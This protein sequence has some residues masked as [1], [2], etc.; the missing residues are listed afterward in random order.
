MKVIPLAAPDEPLLDPD[1]VWDGVTGDLALTPIDEPVNPGG[2]RARQALATAIL[3]C[4]MTDVRAEPSELRDGDV[5]RGWPGDSFER[6]A[7][8]PALGSK[9][10][11]L[12]RRV[13]NAETALLAEDYAR[14]ALQSLIGQGAVARFD[15]VATA[16]PERSR[17]DL[18]I[19]G[20]GRT[21]A[22][23]HD[24]KFAVLWE[25]LNGSV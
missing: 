1:I 7:D 23:V 6:D 10:W 3:I 24:Q 9:L 17:L 22:V 20:Y 4:L 21:G 8:E 2:L 19:T 12:R 18:A 5:N 14:E 25:Q 13:V 15:V 11:L 16:L